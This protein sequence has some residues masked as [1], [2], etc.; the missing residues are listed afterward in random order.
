VDKVVSQAKELAL[1][2]AIAV[3]SSDQF[4]AKSQ[5]D[6]AMIL[7][8]MLLASGETFHMHFGVLKLHLES[9]YRFDDGE[10]KGN[11]F[12]CKGGA[13]KVDKYGQGT[14]YCTSCEKVFVH[15]KLT[16][17]PHCLH[18]AWGDQKLSWTT[19]TAMDA[20]NHHRQ[21]QSAYCNYCEWTFLRKNDP[22]E[23]KVVNGTLVPVDGEAYREWSGVTVT[24]PD[25][26][27][28]TSHFGHVLW[29]CCQLLK[30]V[31]SK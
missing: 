18:K 20:K 26:L 14:E 12:S 8:S 7:G 31:E 17:C 30:T 4:Q 15:T 28:D 5:N 2:C 6:Q 19:T 1:Q 10:R 3:T 16:N 29:K 23:M 9:K 21:Q 11:C 24:V 22:P 27:K 25:S 13:T